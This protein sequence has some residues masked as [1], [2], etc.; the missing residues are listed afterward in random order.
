MEKGVEDTTYKVLYVC[1]MN[2]EPD[3]AVGMGNSM[4]IDDRLCSVKNS[5]VDEHSVDIDILHADANSVVRN[6]QVGNWKLW[7]SKIMGSW[8]YA[9]ERGGM[10][11]DALNPLRS[12]RKL[13]TTW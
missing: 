9:E 10:A 11:G 3:L 8:K 1:L 4:H 2:E 12:W 5:I 13:P 7:A 6:K